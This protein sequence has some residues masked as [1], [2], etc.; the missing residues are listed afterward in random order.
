MAKT[1]DT[2]ILLAG[3]EGTRLRPLTYEVPKSLVKVNGKPLLQYAI[4]ELERNGIRHMMVSAGYMADKIV[5]YIKSLGSNNRKPKI[6]YVVES[7]PLGTG[8]AIKFALGALGDI[9]DFAVVNADTIFDVDLQAMHRMH[10][11]KRAVATIG[12]INFDNV[13]GFGVVNTEGSTIK[14]FVEKPD[15]S[16]CDS[17]TINAGIYVLNKR[18][19]ELFP[20]SDSFSIERDFFSPNVGKV[21]MLSY[22]IK[23]FI[24][25]NTLEQLNAAE[26]I[27][28]E[29]RH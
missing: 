26:K 24:T 23:K 17:H 4:D 5:D 18:V 8:G 1:L 6:D 22:P 27:L 13:A 11:L 12:V 3:G 7:K 21:V 9:D 28:N 29:E 14:S 16:K 15:P 2:A 19:K 25:V 20:K 10:V